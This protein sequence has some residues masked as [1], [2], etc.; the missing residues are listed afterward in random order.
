MTDSSIPEH[1]LDVDSQ[2]IN[3]Y[4]K[5]AAEV[6]RRYEQV[7]SPIAGHAARVFSGGGR[8]LD[9]GCGSGR[10]LAFLLEQGYDAFGIDAAPEL[11][12]LA[13]DLHPSLKGRI[14]HGCLPGLS[15]PFHTQ[16]DAV[17]CSAVLMHL[18]VAEMPS[19]AAALRRCLRGGGRLLVS[20]PFERPDLNGSNRD[21]EG[22]RFTLQSPKQLQSIFENSQF[23]LL[24]EFTNEDAMKRQGVSWI[25]HLYMAS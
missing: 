14:S 3:F 11:V 19:A 8:V 21:P 5:N 1:R 18:D 4:R 15:P 22:R 20:V 9:V 25:S 13:Q 17:L 6:A 10:D 16:F 12:E 23:Q 7:A 24:E 2:T